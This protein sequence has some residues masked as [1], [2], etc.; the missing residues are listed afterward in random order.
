MS[1]F[2]DVL[3]YTIPA[4]VVFATAYFVMKSFMDVEY[5]KQ[6][7]LMRKDG[8][9]LLTPLRLQAFERIVLFLERISLNKLVLR[10]HQPNMTAKVLK[11][12]LITTVNN[13]FDHNIAQQIYI[14]SSS[15]EAIKKAKDEIIGIINLAFRQL[16]PTAKG[17]ELGQKI[18]EMMSKLDKSPTQTAIRILKNEIRQLF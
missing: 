15:W 8:Q 13:E 14:S 1:D 11:D 10:I 17:N 12:V 6:M 16:P 3:K 4:L 7:L 2:L 18:F 9:K 5:K